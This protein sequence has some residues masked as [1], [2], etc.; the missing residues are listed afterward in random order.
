VVWRARLPD[1]GLVYTKLLC[2]R[3]GYLE[4]PQQIEIGLAQVFHDV[5]DDDSIVLRPDLSAKDI[6]DWDSLTHIRLL[7]TIEREF[8]IKFTTTEVGEMKNVGELIA[9][10]QAKVAGSSPRS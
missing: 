10:I 7:F 3:G 5:F 2:A 4:A 1:S 6:P 9:L 8:G